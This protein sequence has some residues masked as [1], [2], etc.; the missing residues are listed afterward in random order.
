M[1]TARRKGTVGIVGL[2]LMGGA[3]ARNLVADGWRVVGYDIDPA[4][5]RAL[6]KAGIEMAA[7]TAELAGTVRTIIISLPNVAA[8]AQTVAA[9]AAARARPLVIIEAGTFAL[10]DKLA[11]A[12]AL[13][14]G[15]HIMLDCPISGTGAQA[16]TRDI[17]V[18]ASGD[19]KAIKR[20]RPLFAGFARSA[21][22]LG[23]LGNGSRMKYVA[24]LLVAINNVAAAEAMV[25]GIKAGLPPQTIYDMVRSG[26]GNSRIFELRAPMM[27]RNRY[28]DATMKVGLWQKDMQVIGEFARALGCPTP[29]F[30]ATQPIYD[31]ALAGGHAADDTASVCAVLEARAGVKR[32][33]AKKA[34]TRRK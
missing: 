26:A 31:A 18:Y 19:R 14:A 20:L 11:A 34:R 10:A 24:N 30:T 15:G 29:L 6:A 4:R 12:R 22:D 28:D 25:L 8:L 2:G 7:D 17:V 23:A 13:K 5:R 9:I 27:V 21:H 1:S 33:R 16:K 3:F 32:K